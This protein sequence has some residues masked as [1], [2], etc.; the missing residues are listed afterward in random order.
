M[1]TLLPVL[2]RE[3]RTAARRPLLWRMRLAAGIVSTLLLLLLIWFF[4][5]FDVQASTG[6][7]GAVVFHVVSGLC[8]IWALFVGAERTADSLGSERRDGTLGLL[9]LT[10]L[11]GW[12]VIMGKLFAAMV[13]AGFQLLAVV[14]V[15]VVPV[16]LGGVSPWQVAG[17]V[18]ALG[19][20][21][22][23]SLSVGLLSSLL[24]RD[25]RQA[26]GIAALIILALVF[27]PWGLFAYLTQKDDPF[28]ELEVAWVVLASPTI[29]FLATASI[30]SLPGGMGAWA[31]A[32]AVGVQS[33]LALAILLI[34]SRWVRVV[35]RDGSTS[36]VRI[37]WSSFRDWLRFGSARKRAEWRRRWLEVGAWEWLS[38]RELRK[39][40]FAWLLFFA[41]VGLELW[42]IAALGARDVI[43]APSGV[44][45]SLFRLLIVLWV[46][47]ESVTTLA[48]QRSL[49]AGELLVTT[50]LRPSDFLDGQD[51]ALHAVLRWPTAGFLL[52]DLA[53]VLWI[54]QAGQ[55]WDAVALGWWLHLT[56]LVLTPLHW[57]AVRWS[58]TRHVLGGRKLNVAVGF[59]FST[60]YLAPCVLAWGVFGT[61]AGLMTLGDKLT[62]SEALTFTFVPSLVLVAAWS[63]FWAGLQ[64]NWVHAHFR[65]S[66]ATRES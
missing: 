63:V 64:R 36:R 17:L 30:P 21:L 62:W 66:W 29:P 60:G 51:R 13:D 37:R 22:F 25:P 48:L 57:H 58:A 61:L 65:D 44:M 16:L 45:L 6:Q 19:N 54:P 20:S 50:G 59:G 2:E 27:I 31:S 55:N 10:D 1:R 18:V 56:G 33:S 38:L 24:S 43:G 28:R 47:G 39:P 32:G 40:R 53:A 34:S 52:L 23:L 14:P 26:V 46:A 11:S 35:W 5:R 12:D 3:L 41:L 8:A 42:Q 4:S 49:G 9:F 15:L 7:V